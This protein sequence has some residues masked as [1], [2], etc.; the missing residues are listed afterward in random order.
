M[1]QHCL[2]P[3]Q[4]VLEGRFEISGIPR[5]RHIA[6]D[7]GIGHHQVDL[8]LRIFRNDTFNQPQV[9]GVH[10]YDTVEAAVVRPVDLPC[11]LALVE[12]HSMLIQAALCR[13]VNRVSYLLRRN[14]RRLDIVL[15]FK[16]FG[17]YQSLQDELCNRTSADITVTDEKDSHLCKFDCGTGSSHH[18][19]TVVLS[20]DLIVDIYADD[21]IGTQLCSTI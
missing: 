15:A 12:P 3:L 6:A 17:L 20:E 16:T 18:K 8:S 13:R 4:Q 2:A 21:S 5:V 7:A 1:I 11:T 10:T 14:R 19:H 9:R